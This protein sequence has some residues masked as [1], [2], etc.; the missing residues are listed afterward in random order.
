MPLSP[1]HFQNAIH[2]LA[3]LRGHILYY[4]SVHFFFERISGFKDFIVQLWAEIIP[5]I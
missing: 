4:A 1:W 3:Q 2:A 5:N